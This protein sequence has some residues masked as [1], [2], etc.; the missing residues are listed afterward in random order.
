MFRTFF[1][2]TSLVLG[3]QFVGLWAATTEINPYADGQMYVAYQSYNDTSSSM[4]VGQYAYGYNIH[5]YVGLANWAGVDLTPLQGVSNATLNIYVQ[6]FLIPDLSNGGGTTSAPTLVSSPTGNFVMKVVALSGAPNPASMNDAW[7]KTNMIDVAGVGS[8]TLTNSGY[9][10]VS[11]GNTVANWISA[12][13]GSRWLGFVGTG[14]ATSNYISVKL[15]TLEDVKNL[16]GDIT[17]PKA[18]MYL[19]IPEPS[20]F[21]LFGSALLSFWMGRRK[22]SKA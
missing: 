15:G 14:S 5:Y 4:N 2:S 19:T 12:G 20:V 9:A 22:R 18:P 17:S 16:D 8:V 11:I 13:S 7:V 3:F 1:L 6:E 10:A 21:G